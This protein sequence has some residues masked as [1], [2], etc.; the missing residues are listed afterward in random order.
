MEGEVL[1]L[2]AAELGQR[3]DVKIVPMGYLRKPHRRVTGAAAY[4]DRANTPRPCTSVLPL[5]RIRLRR[6]AR[7]G[8]STGDLGGSLR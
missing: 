7:I 8:N 2:L 4:V 6:R 1:S 3:N 5:L